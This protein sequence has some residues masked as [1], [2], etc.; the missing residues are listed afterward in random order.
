[1]LDAEYKP[2][3]G[4]LS[5]GAAAFSSSCCTFLLGWCAGYHLP[6]V[7]ALPSVLRLQTNAEAQ[8]SPTTG[9]LWFLLSVV[10]Y[11]AIKGRKSVQQMDSKTAEAERGNKINGLRSQAASC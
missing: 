11:M 7:W 2:L 1:M 3:P 4:M 10:Q 9:A 5:W 8:N 6:A